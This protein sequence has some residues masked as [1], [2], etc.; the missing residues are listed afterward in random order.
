MK[1][2]LVGLALFAAIGSTFTI[3]LGVSLAAPTHAADA[4]SPAGTVLGTTQGWLNGTTVTFFYTRDFVCPQPPASEAQSG[5]EAGVPSESAPIG[6]PD[7]PELWVLVPLG[8]DPPAGTLQCP[9]AGSCVAHPH[10]IDLQNIFGPAHLVVPTPAHSH[11]IDDLQGGWWRSFVVG[12]TDADAWN[13]IAGVG[14]CPAGVEPRSL[15][16]VRYFQQQNLATG[17]IPTNLFLFFNVLPS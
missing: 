7:I 9:V 3:L 8:F 12:I 16:A 10:D 11:V 2:R 13:C 6:N 14:S 17:D 4:P 15:D 1:P 5:C